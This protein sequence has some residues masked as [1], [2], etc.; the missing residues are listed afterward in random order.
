MYDPYWYYVYK[1]VLLVSFKNLFKRT[2]NHHLTSQLALA[3]WSVLASFR[4]LFWFYGSLIHQAVFCEKTKTTNNHNK[5]TVH[6]LF[7]AAQQ[8]DT[9]SD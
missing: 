4:S 8:T 1:H 7:N 5:P 9:V 3:L 6:Y 2:E